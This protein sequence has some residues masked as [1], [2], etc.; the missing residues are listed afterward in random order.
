MTIARL[1][2]GISAAAAQQQFNAVLQQLGRAYPDTKGRRAKLV[3]LTTSMNGSA[4]AALRLL[5]YA[6]IAILAIGC[7]NISGML[8][9][10]GVRLQR[11][12]AVRSV[13]GAHRLAL[14][15]QILSENLTYAIA[16]A[17]VGV[18][19]AYG[20]LHAISV[21]LIAALQ[22]GSEVQINWRVL[23]AAVAISVLVSLLAGL[24]PAL[25]LSGS[26]VNLVLR[27]GTRAGAERVQSRLRA[28]FVVVQVGLALV[29]LFTAGLV[30]RSLSGLRHQDFGFDPSHILTA[31]IDLSAGNY[32]KRDAYVNFY[33]PLLERV[34][35]IPG[36]RSAG[37]IQML[38][39][40]SA[41]WNED[42]HLSGE[43]PNAPTE[44]R[45]A[46]IRILTPGYYSVFGIQLVRGR[47]LNADIDTPNSQRV[48]VV[49]ERFVERYVPKGRDPLTMFIDDGDEKVRIAGVVRNVRHWIYDPPYAEMDWPVSQ[50]PVQMR[51]M[52]LPMMHLAINT[53]GSPASIV[54]ALRRVYRDVDPTL[55]FRTPITMQ[56]II[57]DSLKFER[58]E[59]W[60]F[61]AFG[62]LAF[63]LAVIGIYGVISHEVQSS[64]R[65]I[66][67]RMAVG[68]RRWHIFS[69]VY[70]RVGWLLGVGLTAGVFV[71]WVARQLLN[72][73][74]QI[75]PEHDLGVAALVVLIFASVA[76]LA[77]LMPA[78]TATR[79]DPIEALRTE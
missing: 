78:R 40:Q 56:Q 19:L 20:L 69:L 76:A 71:G 14:I 5:L 66:G 17:I 45:L 72:S 51:T 18:G 31:E 65:D 54:P 37:L 36:V 3:D 21:L 32:Q 38:P 52:I 63:L 57:A 2:A 74:V 46:E 43:P 24:V 62:A 44:E 64:S 79:V 10:R 12:M 68:A 50:I 55:P 15:R 28:A 22:R 9:A 1:K 77:A 60:L 29:L 27:S 13:L 48:T 47:F 11:E 53:A 61:G 8:L 16:G 58:L 34:R 30:F 23:I 4:G 6:V 75:R 26:S 39:I 42:V 49:N 67:V 59:N 7:V 73:V 25:R 70:R 41:G 35:A 33:L